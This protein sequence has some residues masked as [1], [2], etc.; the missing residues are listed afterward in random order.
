MTAGTTL[1]SYAIGLLACTLVLYSPL[2]QLLYSPYAAVAPQMRRA[3]RPA[4]NESLLALDDWS[5]N[6]SCERHGYAVHLFSKAP[7]VFYIEDFL[8][9]SERAHLLEIRSVARF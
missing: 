6:L 9:P 2:S 7:L 1:F 3:P 8:S 4:I 5:G